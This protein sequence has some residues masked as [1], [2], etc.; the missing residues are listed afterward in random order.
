MRPP[1]ITAL[2][3][4][5]FAATSIAWAETYP[6]HIPTSNGEVILADAFD[7]KGYRSQ[8]TCLDSATTG[9]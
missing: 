1:A 7:Q 2:T 8:T 4:T 5:L 9:R 6:V 3:L